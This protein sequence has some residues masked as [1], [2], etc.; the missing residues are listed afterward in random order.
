MNKTIRVIRE[1]ETVDDYAWA[2]AY[3]ESDRLKMADDLTRRAWRMAHHEE[4]PS[5]DRS[6][7]R[8]IMA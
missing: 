2:L 3:S 1:G 4:F 8:L 7:V 5:L 6:R